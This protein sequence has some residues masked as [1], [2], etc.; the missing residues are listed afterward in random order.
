MKGPEGLY[1]SNVV[2]CVFNVFLSYTAITL[3]IIAIQAIR[4]TSTL[5]KT[6]KTF[7]LSMA[8]SDLGVGLL[9]QPLFIVLRIM[10]MKQ[11]TNNSQ[12][13]NTTSIV[14]V[15]PLNLFSYASFFGVMALSADRFLAIHLYLRYKVVVTHK[16]VV[17]VVISVWVFSAFLSLIRL[18]IP[19]NIIFIIFLIIDAVC[20]LAGTFLSVKMLLAARSHINR[21]H[22]LQT[23]Q[24]AQSGEMANVERVR[25]FAFTAIYIYLVLLV[26]YLPTVCILHIGAV[27]SGSSTDMIKVISRY[28]LTLVFLNSTLNPL[29]YCWKMRHIRNTIINIL[30]SLYASTFQ[31]RQD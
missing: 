1:T 24:E 2:I 22:I 3:N 11:N 26:C 19:L 14:Y 15:I 6:L 29:I 25:K 4:K 8:V 12:T 31:L 5:T 10:E 21:I 17:A 23:Q 9:V 7:L 20:W 16:R 30:R 28:T 18:W 27:I 13:Y